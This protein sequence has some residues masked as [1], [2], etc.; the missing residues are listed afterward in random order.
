M[1]LSS[2]ISCNSD[3]K[4]MLQLTRKKSLGFILL[5]KLPP[6]YSTH[7]MG[8]ARAKPAEKQPSNFSHQSA[9]VVMD[10]PPRNRQEGCGGSLSRHWV[11][12]KVSKL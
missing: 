8:F 7:A 12:D 6:C 4:M 11:T 9:L 10:M 5:G 3:H 1:V 2:N